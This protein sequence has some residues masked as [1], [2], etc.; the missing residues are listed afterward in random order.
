M[1]STYKKD[2]HEG[3]GP[4]AFLMG[5]T[6]GDGGGLVRFLGLQIVE[7]WFIRAFLY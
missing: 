6:G 3:A 5:K 1:L 2:L 7:M 4:F